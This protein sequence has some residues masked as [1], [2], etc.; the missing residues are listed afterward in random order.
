METVLNK[1]T[2]YPAKN[3]SKQGV[4]SGRYYVNYSDHIAVVEQLQSELKAER[5]KMARYERALKGIQ[6][7]GHSEGHGR[8]FTCANTAKRALSNEGCE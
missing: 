1:I 6:D 3:L 8:G 5:E 4:G 2:L 7:F